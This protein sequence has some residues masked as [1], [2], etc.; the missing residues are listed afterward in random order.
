MAITKHG[1]HTTCIYDNSLYASSLPQSTFGN[2]V[3]GGHKTGLLLEKVTVTVLVYLSL[4][5]FALSAF[6]YIS[7]RTDSA[8]IFSTII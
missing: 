1:L 6:E 2:A 7:L 4:N 3:S 8:Y 5:G